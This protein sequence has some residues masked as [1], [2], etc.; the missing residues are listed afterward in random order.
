MMNTA[1]QPLE[2]G[3]AMLAQG[4]Q[5]ECGDQ[6]WFHPLPTGLVLAVVDGL[7]H[8]PKAAEAAGAAVKS[9]RAQADDDLVSLMQ[10]CHQALMGTRGAVITLAA[11]DV[12]RAALTWLSVGNVAGMLIHANHNSHMPAREHLLLRGGVVGYRMPKLRLF[13]EPLLPGDTL[14]LTTDG[15]RSTYADDLPLHLPP[16]AMADTILDRYNRKTDDAT[17]VVVRYK[18]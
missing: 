10:S 9:L 2:W 6:Y 13:N 15:V 17:V 5:T 14:I 16:Q 3:A 11:L 1:S 18:G 12:T 8:G 7:G 4:G